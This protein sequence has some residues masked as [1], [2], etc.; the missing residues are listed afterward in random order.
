M[1][2]GLR[3][4][5]SALLGFSLAGAALQ[6]AL[7]A[8]PGLLQSL[9]V[10]RESLSGL[11][12]LASLNLQGSVPLF[13]LVLLFYLWQLS[14][15]Y[16][17]LAQCQPA[18]EEVMRREQLLDLCASLFFGIGVI[19]TAIG[20]R[21]ALLYALGGDAGVAANSG[22]AVLQRLVEGGILL[23]LSTTI[24]GGMGGYL[25]RAGKYL[26]C[27]RALSAL[28]LGASQ[29]GVRENLATLRRIEVH[30]SREGATESAP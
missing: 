28:Y 7:L 14:R 12:A 24:V 4:T 1:R 15:L 25:M 9:H 16:Q 10:W 13:A 27:G 30:L 21:G 23:A 3:F 22:M 19:W 29:L 5:L 18:L 8:A 17:L 26:L 11:W 20:M 6:I 2:G